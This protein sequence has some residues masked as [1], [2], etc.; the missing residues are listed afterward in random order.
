MNK[1]KVFIGVGVLLAL[2]TV[3]FFGFRKNG[4]FRKK[5]EDPFLGDGSLD[6]STSTSTSSGASTSS[7]N[8][9]YGNPIGSKDEVLAFQKFANNKGYSPKLVED[10]LWGTNT[11]NAWSKWSASYL[12]EK[13]MKEYESTLKTTK[14]TST[15]KATISDIT[16]NDLA[17]KIYNAKGGA[18]YKNDREDDV[19]DSLR[20]LSTKANYDALL[21]KF[22]SKYGVSLKDYLKSFLDGLEL[23]R[24]RTIVYNLTPK[25]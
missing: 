10:G 13:A 9:N 6:S 4:W 17:V 14:T 1:K 2:G 19:Y 8:A 12:G 5:N 25:G 18:W 21:I 23:N 11:S 3:A 22:K 24:V 16:L 20:A 7:N 15:S